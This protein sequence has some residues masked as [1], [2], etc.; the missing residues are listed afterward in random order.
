[1]ASSRNLSEYET[2]QLLEAPYIVTV[3]G[4][5][6]Y[7]RERQLATSKDHVMNGKPGYAET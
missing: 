7:I 4:T 6:R 1:M 3:T 5:R 2:F